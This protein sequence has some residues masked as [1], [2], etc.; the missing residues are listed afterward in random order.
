MPHSQASPIR[1]ELQQKGFT[2]DAVVVEC[3]NPRCDHKVTC[4][5]TRN[6][7][8]GR[9]FQR[10]IIQLPEDWQVVLTY[11]TDKQDVLCPDCHPGDL[12][13]GILLL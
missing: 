7:E 6:P 11:G 12:P 2:K 9:N 3:A 5:W 8:P 1:T 10:P 13:E 4:K